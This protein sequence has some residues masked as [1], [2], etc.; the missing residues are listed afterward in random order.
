M[1]TLQFVLWRGVI[2]LGLSLAG[3]F[4]GYVLGS[5]STPVIEARLARAKP[6]QASLSRRRA[7]R[8]TH[9]AMRVSSWN[10][11]DLLR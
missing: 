8:S 10:Q 3:V 11:G 7:Q 9:A 5:P 1:T 4:G 2:A 6:M